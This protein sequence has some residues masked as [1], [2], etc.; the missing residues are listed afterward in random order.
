M[1][2]NIDK[3]QIKEFA[4]DFTE[5]IVPIIVGEDGKGIERF[6]KI[7]EGKRQAVEKRK[8]QREKSTE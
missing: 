7:V 8:V 5:E 2:V 6:K 3:E 1:K 4:K